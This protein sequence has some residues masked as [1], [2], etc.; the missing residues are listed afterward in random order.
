QQTPG[1][2]VDAG[3]GWMPNS[4]ASAVKPGDPVWLNWVNTVY[5]EAMMG[6]D[7]DYFAATYKKWFGIELPTPK[8]GYPNEFA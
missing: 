5:K 4:Y 3:Y 2:F 1:R 8:I 7:F 6:V